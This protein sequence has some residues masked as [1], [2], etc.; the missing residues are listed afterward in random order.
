MTTVPDDLPPWLWSAGVLI[1]AACVGLLAHAALSAVLRR[2]VSRKRT[3]A[4]KAALEAARRP[5]RLAVVPLALLAALP[6]ADLPAAAAETAARVLGIA[7][8]AALGWTLARM[9]GAAFDVALTQTGETQIG[10]TDIDA[11]RRRTQLSLFRRLSVLTVGLVTAGLV[12]TAI[13][14]VRSIGLSLF[15]SAGVAGIVIGI[16]ARPVMANLIAGLQIA[17]AQPIRIGDAVL[18]EGEW[19]HVEEITSTYVVIEIWDERRLVVPLSY[20]LEKPFQNWT[21]QSSKIVQPILLY[22]DYGVPVAAVRERLH[23][24]VR[25]TPLWD[26][27]VWNLQVTELRERTVELRALVSAANSS[28][29]WDLRCHVREQ[30]IAFLHERFPEALPRS[31]IDVVGQPSAAVATGGGNASTPGDAVQRKWG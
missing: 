20:F 1:A 19:G 27:R 5:F 22:V 10:E 17:I 31:R 2:V 3:P 14:V 23:E 26:G 25:S 15:A 28:Q 4:L 6:V 9:I 12:L 16:A 30:L 11:R 24:I 8:V 7:L 21:R 18:V 29:A 13:P